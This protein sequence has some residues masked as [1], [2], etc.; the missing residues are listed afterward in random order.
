VHW[1][2]NNLTE[3]AGHQFIEALS[4][5]S[6]FGREALA[7]G[8]KRKSLARATVAVIEAMPQAMDWPP[9]LVYCDVE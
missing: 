6:E 3:Q 5:S 8:E 4:G 2:R 7:A 1:A 9:Q